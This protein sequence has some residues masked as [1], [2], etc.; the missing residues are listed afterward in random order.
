[1][2]SGN[3]TF[4]NL[5]SITTLKYHV[6]RE[7]KSKLS[8]KETIN[9]ASKECGFSKGT[10][11]K[12]GPFFHLSIET[13]ISIST[14]FWQNNSCC[15]EDVPSAAWGLMSVRSRVASLL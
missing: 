1:M 4:E 3:S 12:N 10:W 14:S 5:N 11:C 13:F 15:S 7:K 6:L 9:F 2:Q 8:Q